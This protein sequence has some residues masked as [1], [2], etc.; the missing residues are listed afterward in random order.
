M[1]TILGVFVA[2]GAVLIS[3][4]DSNT[5]GTAGVQ[6]E[7][8][9]TAS[10][11]KISASGRSMATGAIFR[12]V[13]LGVTELEF[14]SAEENQVEAENDAHDG[15]GDG[16][17][18]NEKVEYHG[19]Y[20]VDLIKGTSTPDF[21]IA[22]LLPGTY[23]EMEINV[24]PVLDSGK[25][26]LVAFDIPRS[27]AD[28][29]KIEFSTSAELQLELER[30]AGF[31]LDGGAL[32]QMLV[33]FNLDSLIENIDFSQAVVDADGIIRI[34]EHSNTDLA[35]HLASNFYHSMEAGEDHDHNEEIDED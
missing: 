28:T 19:S 6:L 12:Q 33:L 14:E 1:K 25:S 23:E 30:D 22:D 8:K 10:I 31:Q 34:N 11:S 3:C 16:E 18:E 20:V 5:P 32:N 17:A 26:I 29:L 21:G 7:M 24:G 13:L 27:G 15:D 9:A 4:N 2:L 35:L